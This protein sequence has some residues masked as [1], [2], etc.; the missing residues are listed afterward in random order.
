MRV[1]RLLP[2]IRQQQLR[3]SSLR[4]P[5]LLL[6][7]HLQACEGELLRKAGTVGRLP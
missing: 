5:G 7:D 2:V 6:A 3:W 1:G 4:R